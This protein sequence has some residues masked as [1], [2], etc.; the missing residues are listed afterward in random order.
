MRYKAMVD[1]L[2]KE[3]KNPEDQE[4]TKPQKKEAKKQKELKRK[5]KQQKAVK[6][7]CE[8]LELALGRLNMIDKREEPFYAL[9]QHMYDSILEGFSEREITKVVMI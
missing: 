7:I 6:I 1:G 5:L 9:T 2:A 4:K 8:N 3:F